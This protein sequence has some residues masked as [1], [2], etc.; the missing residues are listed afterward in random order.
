MLIKDRNNFD[1]V[2]HIGD[3]SYANG[4][5]SQWDQFTEQMEPIASLVPCMVASGNHERDW[6]NMGSFYDMNNSGGECGVL[7]ETMY[8]VP[9]EN[10][11]KF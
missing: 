9:A 11:A 6:P 10:W 5:I 2:F 3:M 7:A 8:Y 4:Y 1:I